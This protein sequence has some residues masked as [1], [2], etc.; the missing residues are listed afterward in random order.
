MQQN[1]EQCIADL[2]MIIQQDGKDMSQNELKTLKKE[3]EK[4]ETELAT[5]IDSVS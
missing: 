5:L 4:L 3:L 1:L 2:H